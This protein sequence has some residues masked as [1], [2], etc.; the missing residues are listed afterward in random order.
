M[1]FLWVSL[2]AFSLG[3]PLD[4]PFG[5]PSVRSHWVSPLGRTSPFG[6]PLELPLGPVKGHISSRTANALTS[7]REHV[8][9]RCNIC[10]LP[11]DWEGPPGLSRGFGGPR[12]KS[13]AQLSWKQEP[14]QPLRSLPSWPLLQD[15]NGNSSF[16]SKK[17]L[18]GASTVFGKA[19][20]KRWPQTCPIQA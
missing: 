14:G 1:N 4:F 13:G 8:A 10:H 11:P 16:F 6:F 7:P 20:M 17:M 19:S 2:C 18:F 5:F 3:F 12:V 15:F 9:Y